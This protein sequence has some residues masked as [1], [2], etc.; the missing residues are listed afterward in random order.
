MGTPFLTLGQALTELVLNFVID[1]NK[2]APYWLYIKWL[3]I[4]YVQR[5]RKKRNWKAKVT[6]KNFKEDDL[7]ITA[8]QVLTYLSLYG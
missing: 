8:Y 5:R 1:W 4:L 6:K 2:V 7:A 3:K